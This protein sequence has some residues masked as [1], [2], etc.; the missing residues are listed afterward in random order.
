MPRGDS[1]NTTMPFEIEAREPV[2]PVQ[3]VG[4]S[5]LSLRIEN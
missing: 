5:Q 4:E 1:F 2:A 3:S